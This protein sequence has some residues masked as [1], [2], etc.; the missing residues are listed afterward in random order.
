MCLFLSNFLLFCLVPNR[1]FG[2]ITTWDRPE[3]TNAFFFVHLLTL[4]YWLTKRVLASGWVFRWLI[5]ILYWP[6][7]MWQRWLVRAPLQWWCWL[8]DVAAV[9]WNTVVKLAWCERCAVHGFATGR[10]YCHYWFPADSRDN[11]HKTPTLWLSLF[12]IK[13][14]QNDRNNKNQFT[15]RSDDNDEN[16]DEDHGDDSDDCC[17]LFLLS[18]FS[19]CPLQLWI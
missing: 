6:R 9:T 3:P 14:A 2:F 10:L 8:G 19:M 16:H 4:N 17:N 12:S 1:F 13:R 15:H 11:L 7:K 5:W 18:F